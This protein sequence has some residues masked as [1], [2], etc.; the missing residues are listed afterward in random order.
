M[1]VCQVTLGGFRELTLPARP[2]VEAARILRADAH[3]ARIFDE[4]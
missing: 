1:A 3:L 2:G 4:K